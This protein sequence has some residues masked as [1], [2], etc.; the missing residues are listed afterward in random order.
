MLFR[1]VLVHVRGKR[2][3]QVPILLTEE[4]VEAIDCLNSTRQAVGVSENNLYVFA[5]PSRNSKNPIRGYQCLSNITKCIAG[6]EKPELIKSTK[7]RKYVATVAQ[8][9]QLNGSLVIW[10]T[11]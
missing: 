4:F 7:L 1:L 5:T 2:G 9:S 8:V 6:M 10:V 3:R 11:I